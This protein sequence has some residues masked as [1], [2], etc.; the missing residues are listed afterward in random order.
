MSDWKNAYRSFYYETAAAPEDI[1]LD[2][3][4]NL[5]IADTLNHVVRMV[6]AADNTSTS[7]GDW[8][9]STASSPS[10]IVPF[11]ASSRC[12]ADQARMALRRR[13]HFTGFGCRV[14]HTC[15]TQHMFAGFKCSQ[16]NCA[17][18]VGPGANQHGIDLIF[19]E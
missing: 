5:Y 13:Q 12:M 14:R 18:H 3:A 7:A 15:L 10:E 11:C 16:G 1:A 8:P 6:S 4:G 2:Q 17:M 9:R 19:G